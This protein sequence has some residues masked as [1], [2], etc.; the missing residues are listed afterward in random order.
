MRA[1]LCI[2]AT[3]AVL[4]A[5]NPAGAGQPFGFEIAAATRVYALIRDTV[6]AQIHLLQ[7]LEA[8]DRFSRQSG[9]GIPV[10]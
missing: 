6:V 1:T 5:S 7:A 3:I 10:L 2:G 4:A 9:P 8:A